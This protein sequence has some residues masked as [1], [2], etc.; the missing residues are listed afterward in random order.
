M[1]VFRFDLGD[2]LWGWDGVAILPSS[3]CFFSRFLVSGLITPVHDYAA[4][5]LFLPARA[6]MAGHRIGCVDD[7]WVRVLVVGAQCSTPN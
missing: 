7:G 1:C 2:G 3:L 6:G 4:V 5:L